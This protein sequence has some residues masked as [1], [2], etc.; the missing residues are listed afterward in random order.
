M[1]QTTRLHDFSHPMIMFH[2]MGWKK[3]MRVRVIVASTVVAVNVIKGQS[4][5]RGALMCAEY[6]WSLAG[7]TVSRHG[8]ADTLSG[9]SEAW[10]K[11]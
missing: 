8:L 9:D 7:T 11:Q 3:S 1:K 6:W 10:T 2:I 4:P 5:K